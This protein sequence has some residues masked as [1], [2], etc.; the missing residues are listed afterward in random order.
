MSDDDGLIERPRIPPKFLN[1]LK[2]L[3][4]PFKKI[5]EKIKKIKNKNIQNGVYGGVFVALFTFFYTFSIAKL[6]RTFSSSIAAFIVT[7]IVVSIMSAIAKF[8]EK[9][10]QYTISQRFGIALGFAL[11]LLFCFAVIM[12]VDTQIG[13]P[14]YTML[15]SLLVFDNA[16]YKNSAKD[17][18]ASLGNSTKK[19]FDDFIQFMKIG[20]PSERNLLFGSIIKY[21]GVLLA[22]VLICIALVKSATDPSAMTRNMIPYALLITV[23]LLLSLILFSPVIKANDMPLLMM[24]GG[25]FIIFMILI[26]SYYSMSWTPNTVYYGSYVMN[27]LLAVIV[28][29]GLGIVFK[30]FS[31]Q[32]KKL[33]GWPGFFA[34]LFFFIPCLLSDGLQ[35]LFYQFKITPNVVIL[36]LFIEIALILLYAYMPVIMNKILQKDTTLLLDHPV[37]INRELPIGNSSLFLL[38]P[39]DDNS[40]YKQPNPYRTNY[41]FSMW[42]YL[43]PQSNSNSGYENGAKIFDFGNGKPSISYKNQSNNTRL[44]NKDIYEIQFTNAKVDASFNRVETTYE[45]SLP[46]Q[47]WNNFVFNYFDSKVDLYVNGSLERTFEFSNNMPKYEPTDVITVGSKYGLLG[48]ICNVHYYKTPLSAEKISTLY[49]LL[50]LKN[51]PFSI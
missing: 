45:I 35:Y 29:I 1:F 50:Y 40:V 33:S 14:V 37:F 43:N 8:I 5:S 12:I 23:P 2:Q 28:I 19:I 6:G 20:T 47:K 3:T 9:T 41:T 21:L 11:L 27:T 51:P 46:N 26:F 31:G 32:F 36:L 15:Y 49:N 30:L 24:L 18:F 38:E 7:F 22:I 4:I 42:I 17:F 39:I 44:A 34:N 25:G 48:A 13:N 10:K 16:L